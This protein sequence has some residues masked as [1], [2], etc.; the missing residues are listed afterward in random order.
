MVMALG[1]AVLKFLHNPRTRI[2]RKT[3]H[4]LYNAQS[5]Q[6][7]LKPRELFYWLFL[8]D[9]ASCALFVGDELSRLATIRH[10]VSND[11][12]Y[13]SISDYIDF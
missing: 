8:F 3:V 9:Q 2:Q 1:G 13:Q 7:K 10:V 11:Y 4:Y 6:Y 12:I 5:T